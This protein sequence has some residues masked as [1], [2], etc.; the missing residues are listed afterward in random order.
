MADKNLNEQAIEIVGVRFGKA[1]STGNDYMMVFYLK[2]VYGSEA[3]K[4]RGFSGENYSVLVG[5]PAYEKLSKADYTTSFIAIPSLVIVA[6]RQTPM[7][8]DIEF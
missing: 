2:P 6:G 1:K 5:S 7:I 3:S 4:G 8:K